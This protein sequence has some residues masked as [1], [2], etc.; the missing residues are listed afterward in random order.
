[1]YDNKHIWL[2]VKSLVFLFMLEVLF[3]LVYQKTTSTDELGELRNC[4]PLEVPQISH[5]VLKAN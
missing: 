5:T 3:P 1:M 4:F 2:A